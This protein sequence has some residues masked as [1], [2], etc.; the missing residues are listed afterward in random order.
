MP[1][2]MRFRVLLSI[3]FACVAFTALAAEPAVPAKTASEGMVLPREF[4]GWQ[5][6]GSF[7]TSKDEATADPTN[8][9]ILKEYGFTDVSSG[10]L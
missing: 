4:G 7:Q 2:K 8:P 5:L 6:Q 3:M 1:A 10:C 9:A